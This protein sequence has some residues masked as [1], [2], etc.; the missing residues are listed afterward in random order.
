MNNKAFTLVELLATIV[1][2]SLLAG[3]ATVSYTAIIHQSSDKV[4]K[5]YEETMHAEAVYKMT[6][7]PDKVTFTDGKAILRF[8]DLE[9][10]KF[11]N[12]VDPSDAC[13]NSYVE[14]T[15]SRVNG[16]LSMHY[17]VCL[18]CNAHNSD[19]SKCRDYEN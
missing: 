17:K 1:I 19:G 7:H 8:D 15:K 6:M 11:N 4:F 18:I 10:E 2:I 13:L 9:I 16:V 3:I 14:V 12:P 5:S